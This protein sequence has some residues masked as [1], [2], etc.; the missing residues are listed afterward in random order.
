MFIRDIAKKTAMIP[1]FLQ[2]RMIIVMCLLCMVFLAGCNS[3]IPDT[4]F[5][6]NEEAG[7]PRMYLNDAISALNDVDI[8]LGMGRQ[9]YTIHNV[10]GRNISPDGRAAS[11]ILSVNSQDPFYF[12][13]TPQK[14]YTINWIEADKDR[15][16]D[17]DKE[18]SPNELFS[19]HQP[20]FTSLTTDSESTI[21]ELQLRNGV[22]HVS[23]NQRRK[24]WEYAFDSTTGKQL[25]EEN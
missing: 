1:R 3:K 19:K 13:C 9:P 2:K 25:S 24:M 10:I 21:D 11:W 18:L 20:L 6:E 17:F 23:G 14:F 7:S 5:S 8:G 12:V 15:A 22:Y 4:S 16:I